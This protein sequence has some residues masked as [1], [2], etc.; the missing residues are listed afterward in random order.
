MTITAQPSQ[1]RGVSPA[2]PPALAAANQ[3][4]NPHDLAIAGH[5]ALSTC[6][7]PGKLVTTVFLQGCPWQCGYCHNPDL[8]P[9][10]TAGV[11]PWQNV[12]DLLAK[13]R[14]LLDG[15]VF[16]GGEPTRQGKLLAAAMAE[17][18]DLGFKVGLHSGGAYPKNLELVLPYVDWLGLDVKAPMDLYQAITGRASSA[19]MFKA[20]LEVVLASGVDTQVR[21][22]VDPTVLSDDDVSRLTAWLAERGVTDHVLQTVRPDGTTEEFQAKLAAY[23][24]SA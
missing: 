13:R 4:V 9:A 11:I 20:S 19:R 18:K 8:I 24:K 15:V 5:V 7:W 12:L 2:G 22:T 17:V 21:T 14:G 16:S 3:S 6:D 23:R 1:N 10:R